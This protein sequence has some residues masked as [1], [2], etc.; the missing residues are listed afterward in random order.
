MKKTKTDWRKMRKESDAKAK[1]NSKSKRFPAKV[2]V[3]GH[4]D[5]RVP[6]STAT[7]RQLMKEK[8]LPEAIVKGQV[9][10]PGWDGHVR[11][12]RLPNVA[13]GI[14]TAEGTVGVPYP[15]PAS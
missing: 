2:T 11:F 15:P 14:N 4:T 12:P 7:I 3:P 9:L 10:R 8:G 1:R 5:P 13:S 6:A